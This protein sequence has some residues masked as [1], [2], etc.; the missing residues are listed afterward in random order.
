MKRWILLLFTLCFS[1]SA[2][3]QMMSVQVKKS[4][5]KDAPSF[6]AKNIT[7][8]SY[9]DQVTQIKQKGDWIQIDTTLKKGWLHASALTDRKVILRSGSQRASTT[10]SSNEVM[11]AGKGFNAQ[12]ES[13]YR[14]KNPQMRFDLV[15]KMERYPTSSEAERTFAQRGKLKL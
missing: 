15:D 2:S 6:L 5:L 12:V 7:T 9:G 11:L 8:L 13:K 1:I 14:Q 10:V 4:V 3:A